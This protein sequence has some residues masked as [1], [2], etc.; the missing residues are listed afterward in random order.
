[1]LP[2]TLTGCPCGLQWGTEEGRVA[3][4]KESDVIKEQFNSLQP[5]PEHG[6]MCPEEYRFLMPCP[7]FDR[8]QLTVTHTVKN[9]E[10]RP[11]ERLDQVHV[12]IASKQRPRK[13]NILY[14]GT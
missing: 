14:V 4:K 12:A 13:M 8:M 6:P 10:Y 3:C 1:L 11:G 9:M 2:D 5:R 7:N